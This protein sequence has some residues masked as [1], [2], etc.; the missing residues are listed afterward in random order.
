MPSAAWRPKRMHSSTSRKRVAVA[1]ALA[2]I[3]TA[4]LVMLPAPQAQAKWVKVTISGLTDDGQ[5]PAYPSGLG[6]NTADTGAP[7]TWSLGIYNF[8]GTNTATL[9][10]WAQANGNGP[11][12]LFDL[13]PLIGGTGITGT[14]TPSPPDIGD[15][16]NY[17][18]STSKLQFN[19]DRAGGTPVFTY[20]PPATTSQEIQGMAFEGNISGLIATNTNSDIVAFLEKA[21]TDS[22]TNTFS[23]STGCIGVARPAAESQLSFTWTQVK[24]E[25]QNDPS[26]VPGPL[27]ALGAL[28]AYGFSRRLRSRIRASQSSASL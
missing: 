10:D 3:G 11:P 22:G 24:F 2:S 17:N 16:F 19:W 23:C 25:V 1:T 5:Q 12:Y 21:I 15:A 18:K 6:D 14:N 27:P 28:G 9:A 26:P 8:S 4:A 7:F 20:A 13:S